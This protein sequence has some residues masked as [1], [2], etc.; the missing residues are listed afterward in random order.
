MITLR[1]GRPLP[2]RAGQILA[3]AALLLGLA[4]STASAQTGT[5]SGKVTDARSS[6]PVGGARVQA[7]TGTTIA[8]STISRED[9]SYRLTVPAGS[10]IV[11]V[12]RIGFSPFRVTNVAVT[13]GGTTT[14]D[15]Q[16]TE[17]AM[18][19]NPVV[20]TASRKEEKAL[21][22]PASV[23]V[24]DV[25][26]IEERPSVTVADHLDGLAGVNI[27]KGGVAQ[28]NIVARGFNNAFSGSLL[29]LQDYRFAAVPSLRVNVPVLF[30]ASNEDIERVEVLLGPASALYGPNSSHGVLHVITKTPFSSQGTT[31]TIDG[32]T[33]SMLRASVRHA[34]VVSDK[35][36][37]KVSGEYF[38]ATD[39]KDF[40]AHDSSGNTIQKYDPGEPDVFPTAAPAG[41]RGLPNT[42]SFDIRRYAGEARLDIRPAANSEYVSTFGLSHL[43]SGL[44]YTG[45]NGTALGKNWTYMSAQQRM[46]VG[47]FFAQVFANFSDAGN[48]DSLDISGTY[49]LRSG[50]PIVDHSRVIA[51]QVQHGFAPRPWQDFIY[52]LDYIATTPRTG[53][54]I[55]GRNEDIDNVR[56]VGGYVQSTTNLGKKWDFVAALRVDNNDQ[57]DGQ[58]VSPRAALVFKPSATQN[59]RFT[60]NRAFGTP[61]NFTWFLD[62]IQARNVGGLP[63]NVRALGN[64]PKTGWT[65]NRGCNAAVSG[66]LC[67]RTIFTGTAGENTWQD[68]SA[69]VAYKGVIAGNA[70]AI[71]AGL[72]PAIQAGLGVPAAVAAGVAQQLV[73]V[74]GS[75]QPTP[76]QVG[77]EIRYLGTTNNLTPANVQDIGPIKASFNNTYELGY[78]GII[79]NRLRLAIDGWSEKRGDVGNPAGLATPNIFFN[80]ASLQQ[81]MTTS[82][83]PAITA[84][85][86]GPPFN[87]PAAQAQGTAQVFAPQIASTVATNFAPLPLGI[88][89]FN[90]DRFASA[91][92]IFATYTSYNK[93]VTVEGV[94]L[95]ADLIANNY[96]TVAA[97]YSWVSDL[98]FPDVS[99][100]N[101]LPL[102]LNAPDNKASLAARF[103][104]ERRGYGFELR[105]RY[106]NGYPVNSGVYA[107]DVFFPRPGST[108]TYE[109]YPVKTAAL[110]DASFNWRLSVAN[111]KSLLWSVNGDNVLG[112]GYRT[113][114]GAPLIGRQVM[115]RLQYTF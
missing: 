20:T 101:Q 89:S 28:S 63:Y 76:A 27:S 8:S 44:E 61:A 109:Y 30:T 77:T 80:K 58:Q 97:T 88:I 85:L 115:T 36:G 43:G 5:I 1:S 73:T 81:F 12:L 45:A 35:V 55:N 6:M 16:L 64:P 90:N 47:R 114:P 70:A 75:F 78:K 94:D 65:F 99:S 79:G 38:T 48:K 4:A 103:R 74:L 7:I 23:S 66:G 111:T 18:E 10:Y 112:H 68:A 95:A 31:A 91:R 46:R 104:D 21:V 52:G 26:A 29:T 87:M 106:T 50:Q 2:R 17:T 37:Y 100:S 72:A 54:T 51:A 57:I 84:A 60:Y 41:R 71:A 22:A 108:A 69:A 11:T 113:M 49:L 67:M 110:F 59:F 42:R 82:L 105:G 62:L 25:R 93:T 56:E 24:V 19:L 92:D 9:G 15:A 98:V 3:T 33:Q 83:V 107:T 39:F 34:A 40:M 96:W 53:N 86:Q 14:T 13:A 102:M 32:G